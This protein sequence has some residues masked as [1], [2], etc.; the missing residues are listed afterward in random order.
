[1][2][3]G[4]LFRACSSSRLFSSLHGLF[5]ARNFGGHSS[6]TIRR[7]FSVYQAQNSTQFSGSTPATKMTLTTTWDGQATQEEF[8]LKDQCILVN[9]DDQVT[10]HSSKYD[11]HRFIPDQPQGLLHRA[12]SVFLFD[13]QNRLLLQQRA[14]SKIT[15]PRVW[16][17]TCCSHPLYGYEPTEVD[18]DADIS[19]GTVPGAKSAAIRKLQ[20]ELGISPDQVPPSSFKYLTRLHYSAKDIDTYGDDAEWGEHEIDYILFI[21]PGAEINLHPH[22]EEVM[23]V[24]YVTQEELEE[25]MRPESGLLWSPWFQ[26]IAENFLDKWWRDLD[27]TMSTDVHIDLKKIHKIM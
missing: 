18:T 7:I 21:K 9:D 25:M 19:N 6:G 5:S 13:D 3:S 22:P 4:L 8:M 23:D 15:F 16:T 17:N 27:K 20:H 2:C 10:G 24:K 14:A 11:S 12:F 1:M 26:I